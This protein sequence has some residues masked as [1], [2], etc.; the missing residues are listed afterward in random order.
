MHVGVCTLLILFLRPRVVGYGVIIPSVGKN[1][2]TNAISRSLLHLKLNL[3][4][5]RMRDVVII[6]DM[7]G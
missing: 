4:F 1:I 2:Q 5:F 3:E 6:R 7:N